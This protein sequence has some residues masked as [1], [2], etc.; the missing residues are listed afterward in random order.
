MKSFLSLAAALL[1][2]SALAAQTPSPTTT[3]VSDAVRG[4][5]AR[6][7]KIMPAAA[8]AMPADKFSGKPTPDQITFAHLTLH[9]AEANFNFCSKLTGNAVPDGAKLS[10]TDPKDKLVA[11]LKN[12]FAF[13]D[14]ALAKLDDSHLADPVQLGPNR[15]VTR[16]ALMFILVGSWA[17]HYSAQSAYLR[18]SGILPPTAQ[19]APAAH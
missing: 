2:A 14:A 3:P 16:A 4:G 15:T 18:Q 17:D 7:G 10:D 13:C 11:N 9:I 6:Y 8:D 5:L 12:S 19:P 1:F